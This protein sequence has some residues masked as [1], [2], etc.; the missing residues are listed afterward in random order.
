MGILRRRKKKKMN[1]ETKAK[2][3]NIK[4]EGAENLESVVEEV[5]KRC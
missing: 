1:E 4:D 3:E 2:E 5:N